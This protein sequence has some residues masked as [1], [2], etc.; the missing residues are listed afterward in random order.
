MT[1]G[2]YVYFE[3]Y[4][5]YDWTRYFGGHFGLDLRWTPAKQRMWRA[6]FLSAGVSKH[7]IEVTLTP[8][9]TL[10][11]SRC[12]TRRAARTLALPLS[13]TPTPSPSPPSALPLTLTPTFAHV[14]VLHEDGSRIGP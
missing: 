8:T 3:N 1:T 7:H 12:D 2:M 14:E 6:R 4:G 9:L 10:T 5:R 11:T 13:P